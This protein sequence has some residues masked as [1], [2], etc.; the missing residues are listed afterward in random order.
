MRP[1]GAPAEEAAA[2]GRGPGDAERQEALAKAARPVEQGEAVARQDG[3]EDRRAFRELGGDDLA[4][5]LAARHLGV[6]VV[7]AW[8]RHGCLWVIPS[9]SSINLSALEAQ[10]PRP[11]QQANK[12]LGGTGV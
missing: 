7:M 3:L 8:L 11:P 5:E 1:G 10:A 4:R 12:P 2:R 6:E 9:S